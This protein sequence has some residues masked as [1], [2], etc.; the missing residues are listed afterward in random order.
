LDRLTFI[1]R[2]MAIML[3]G[4]IGWA[5][6]MSVAVNSN[7]S[8]SETSTTRVYSTIYVHIKRTMLGLQRPIIPKRDGVVHTRVQR[9]Q[10]NNILGDEFRNHNARSRN[11]KI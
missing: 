2:L 9:K 10:Y 3:P 4:S 8:V 11:L 1:G 5:S 6:C 7:P